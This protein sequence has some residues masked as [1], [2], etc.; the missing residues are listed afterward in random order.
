MNLI[1]ADSINKAA[2][3]MLEEGAFIEAQET[4]KK[5][6]KNNPCLMTL[7]NLGVFYISEGLQLS[8]GKMRGARKLGMK[9]LLKAERSDQAQ[10]NLLAI[11]DLCFKQR[12]FD[13]ACMYYKKADKFE[14]SYCVN[15]NWGAALYIQGAYD[16]S[17]IYLKKALEACNDTYDKPEIVSTYAFALLQTDKK[18]CHDVLLSYKESVSLNP[19]DEFVLLYLCDSYDAAAMMIKQMF[20]EYFVDPIVMAMI[21]DCLLRLDKPD[22]A[23]LYYELELELLEDLDYNMKKEIE[24]LK[25]A[26]VQ[27]DYRKELVR[28]YQYQPRIIQHAYYIGSE[29]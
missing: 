3:E 27:A 4:L 17:L 18:K 14:E 2:L 1:D 24:S 13:R 10:Q 23:K 19:P 26:F 7:N 15:N 20:E 25:Q 5:N 6:A 28:E 16:E 12:D 22:E 29:K 11:G 9:Y 8:S 21:V